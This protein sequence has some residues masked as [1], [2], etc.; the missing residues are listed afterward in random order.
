MTDEQTMLGRFVRVGADVGVIVGL[1]DGQSIPDEHFAVWYGQR[2]VDEV[3]PL[4]RTVPREYC[5]V[6]AKFATYH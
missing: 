3:T 5:E 1:P 2:L 4:A 6:I